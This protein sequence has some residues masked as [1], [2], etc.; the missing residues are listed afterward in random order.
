MQKEIFVS[1]IRDVYEEI[2]RFAEKLDFLDIQLLRKFYLTNKPFPN[3]T[4]V[5]CFP[6]LYQEMKTTH[7]LKLSLEGLRKRLN[8]LVKLGLLEKINHSNPTT[9]APVKGKETFVRAIIKKFF[10]IN[11]LTQF[12]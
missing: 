4:K 6:L 12:L 3:D 10:L 1:E 8:N 2:D 11:G 9:Y 7:R 5:W